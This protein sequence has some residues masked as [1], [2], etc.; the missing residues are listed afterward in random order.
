MKVHLLTHFRSFLLQAPP[1]TTT[2]LSV[3]EWREPVLVM[4]VEKLSL[5]QG[6][7]YRARV[8]LRTWRNESRTW[9]AAVPFCLE[10]TPQLRITGLPCLN[11]R[12]AVDAQ[13][14][15]RFVTEPQIRFLFLSADLANASDACVTWPPAQRAT[16]RRLIQAIEGDLLGERLTSAFDPD[17][18]L[19]RQEFQRLLL[20]LD[21][22]DSAWDQ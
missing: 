8:G 5:F 12:R 19:A 22:S 7:E 2:F 16:A 4:R 13:M 18:E 14:L 20:T 3:Q 10:V 1:Y 9:V 15:Q 11:P 6:R 17:F 21:A